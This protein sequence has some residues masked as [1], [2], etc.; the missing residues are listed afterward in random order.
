VFVAEVMRAARQHGR[1]EFI[2]AGPCK[3]GGAVRQRC[4]GF[5]LASVVCKG[6]GC[7]CAPGHPSDP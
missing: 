2:P 4:T 7:L 3:G 5:W 6:A 1:R